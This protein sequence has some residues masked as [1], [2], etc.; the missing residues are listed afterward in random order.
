[1]MEKEQLVSLVNAAQQGDGK[2]LNDLFNAFYNDV[3]YFALKTVKD[4]QLACDIT[5]ETFMEIINTLGNLKEPAAFVTWM[6]QIT[7]HQCTRYFK[8]KKDV[9][10]DEDEDGNTVFDNLQEENA[11]FIP[12]EALERSD[13]K[14]IIMDI[15]DELSEEQ[16]AATM[17]Y[18]FDEMSVK[19]IAEIQ[20]VSE[21]TIKSRLNYARK[22]IRSAIEAYEKKHDIKLHAIPFFPLLRWAFAGSAEN[23]MSLAAAETVATGVS[24]ATGTSLAISSTSV[25]ATAAAT[26]AATAATTATGIGAKIIALP[27]V[28]KIVAGVSA[29]VIVAGSTAAVTLV[30]NNDTRDDTPDGLASE[31]SDQLAMQRPT[32]IT[33]IPLVSTSTINSAK[34]VT[35]TDTKPTI[36]KRHYVLPEGL[37]YTAVTGETFRGGDFV[38]TPLTQGDEVFDG[39]YVYRYAQTYVYNVEDG[40]GKWIEGGNDWSVTLQD[41]TRSSYP[42][43]LSEIYDKPIGRLTSTYAGCVNLVESPVLPES[44]IA[45]DATFEGCTALKTAPKLPSNL[46]YMGNTFM[47]CSSLT[48]TPIIPNSVAN[49]VNAFNR[50]SSLTTITNLPQSLQAMPCAFMGTAI[51]AAPDIPLYVTDMSYAF[52]SCQNLTTAYAVPV[53]VKAA[54]FV[55]ADCPKLTGKIEIHATLTGKGVYSTDETPLDIFGNNSPALPITLI[56]NSPQLAEIAAL[57]DNVTVMS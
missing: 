2:A 30:A 5:Q 4:D 10:V 35:A 24:A 40:T 54:E 18:Y 42:P 44:V 17:M 34:T 11:E 37:T 12:D 48:A 25:A 46:V 56:G 50:C 31:I 21:G 45:M 22:S 1:M 39:T 20:G 57:Y 53:G 51:T 49:L 13:L 3:Y 23:A 38:T 52:A 41:R 16:R 43:V 7:Y 36:T 8:K 29:A 28:T 47:D 9:L 27:L 32:V 15:L 55:F 26:T 19:Q 33:R 14:K 6:K